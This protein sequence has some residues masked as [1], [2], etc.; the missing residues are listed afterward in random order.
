MAVNQAKLT[1]IVIRIVVG[2]RSTLDK[3]SQKQLYLS[4]FIKINDLIPIWIKY[5]FF[6]YWKDWGIAEWRSKHK[7]TRLYYRFNSFFFFFSLLLEKEGVGLLLG[8]LHSFFRKCVGALIA[9]KS[10]PTSF[11]CEDQRLIRVSFKAAVHLGGL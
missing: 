6:P 8:Q 2:S 11:A 1:G 4:H 3:E 7:N 9:L 10:N 5:P